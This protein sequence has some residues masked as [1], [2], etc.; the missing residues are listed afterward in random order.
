MHDNSHSPT[1][2]VL[3]RP[4]VIVMLLAAVITG[5]VFVLL[6]VAGE[7]TKE[8]P[9]DVTVRSVDLITL[10]EP[11]EEVVPPEP[12]K[13]EIFAAEPTPA[14]EK[15]ETSVDLKPLEVESKT[16]VPSIP[17]A[18]FALPE[19]SLAQMP[20]AMPEVFSIE[21]VDHPP[22]PISRIAPQYPWELRRS[23]TEGKVVIVMIIDANG[24]VSKVEVESSTH[25]G[26]EQPS[27]EAVLKWR[28]EPA[29]MNGKSV[30]CIRKI[31]IPFQLR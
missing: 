4:S 23:K 7:L 5:L 22:V 11:P 1:E 16:A 19:F 12:K 2:P 18:D 8:P 15:K 28:F 6:P 29:R 27:I 9:A 17:S 24:A 14:F 10:P 25:S 3:G 30:S 21:E 13:T 26:F 20:S 31:Q